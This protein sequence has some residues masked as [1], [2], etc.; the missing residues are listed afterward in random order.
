MSDSSRR[1][2]PSSVVTALALLASVAAPPLLGSY[3]HYLGMLA[4]INVI[5]AVGLN[6]LTG[7]AGQI[8]LCNS[9]FMA[10][11]AYATTYL[12]TKIGVAYWISLPLGGLV[13]AASG[14]ALGFPALRLRGFYLA[15]VTLGF[16]ALTQVLVEQLPG[17]TGGVRGISSPRPFLFGYHLTSD[18]AFYYVV[19]AIT[20]LAIW[21]A[22]SLLR[23]PT[24]RALNAIRNNEAV[25]QTLAIPLARTKLI[26][27][28]LSALY[29]GLSGGLYATAVGF[30]DPLEFGVSTSIRHII[31]I[32]VG[33][34]GT[35]SGSIIGAAL[36]TLLPELLRSFQEYSDLV[37]GAILLVALMTLPR[38]LVSLWPTT[39]ARIR[40]RRS[41]A[42]A[43]QAAR[44][45]R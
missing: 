37:F 12:N 23:S 44:V 31:Y 41:A 42:D 27:F 9:S 29:A 18:L 11:G 2:G 45:V 17:I 10:I 13:A 6:I 34:L 26:A 14:F 38:G 7:N 33:G 28:M 19:L 24:G 21:G 8:S 5:A 1:L 15:V 32:V 16:L 36:L 20:L 30:I 25:A 43:A 3:F 35:V 4:L 40:R 39:E 22:V